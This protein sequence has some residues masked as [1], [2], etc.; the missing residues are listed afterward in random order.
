MAGIP[1]SEDIGVFVDIVVSEA[2]VG[3]FAPGGG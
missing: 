3:N 1:D 2:A